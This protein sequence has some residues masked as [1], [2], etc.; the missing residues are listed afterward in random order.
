MDSLQIEEAAL[1][2]WPALK[3][4]TYD[5]WVLRFSGGYTKRANSVNPLYQSI[6]GVSEKIEYCERAY[7]ERGLP[8]IFRLIDPLAPHELDSLLSERGYRV[9]HPTRVMGLDLHT[10]EP[11]ELTDS[12]MKIHTLDPWLDIFSH[13]SGY[14]L[15]KQ[16]L[17]KKILEMI[18]SAPLFGSRQIAGQS[19]TCGLGVMHNDLFGL[20]DI[21]THPDY[22]NQGLGREFVSEMLHWGKARGARVAY[23]QVMES[24]APALHLYEKLGFGDL[25]RYWYRVP[26]SM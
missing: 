8:P 13:L 23:L 14:S 12:L 24:N 10:W 16:P 26:E 25:Y 6:L 9:F 21:V 15:E 7:V 5:G 4:I 11:G 1:Q 22:R 17:H 19:V 20:F 18:P 3:Q 2:A